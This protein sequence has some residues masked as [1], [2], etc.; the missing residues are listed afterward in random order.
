MPSHTHATLQ[1]PGQAAL[2]KIKTH[3]KAGQTVP[4]AVAS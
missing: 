2:L 3:I 1:A 4:K